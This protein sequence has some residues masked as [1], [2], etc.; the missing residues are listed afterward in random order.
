MYVWQNLD[1]PEWRN[2][3]FLLKLRPKNHNISIQ[4]IPTLLAQH[5]KLRPSDRTL[6]CCASLATLLRRVT[7]CW[8]LK[9]ELVRMPGRNTV[10][11][12]WPNE[13]NIMH[14]PQMSLSNLSQQHPTFCDMSQQDD[15][16]RATCKDQQC[17]DM[18]RWDVV[19][20]FRASLESGTPYSPIR[21]EFKD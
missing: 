10:A 14:H 3:N 7:T 4:H 15:Q 9:I 11:R 1:F 16:T 20:E 13:H 2:F 6:H 18:L 8:V 21:D 17:C 12:T 5:C 19:I